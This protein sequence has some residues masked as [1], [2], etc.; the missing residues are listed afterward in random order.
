MNL[1]KGWI[2]RFPWHRGTIL[3]KKKRKPGSPYAKEREGAQGSPKNKKKNLENRREGGKFASR[4]NSNGVTADK[5]SSYQERVFM[6][7]MHT[8][9]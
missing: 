3:I 7:E 6:E 9:T 2:R 1:I 4:S 8:E 5:R